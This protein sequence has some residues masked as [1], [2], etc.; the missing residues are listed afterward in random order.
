M[1]YIL[2]LFLLLASSFPAVS[3]DAPLTYDRI[4]LSGTATGEVAN[5]TVVALLYAQ[6][7]GQQAATLA[8][9]VNAAI[10]WALAQAAGSEGIKAQTLDYQTQPVYQNQRLSGWRVR[11]SLRLEGRDAGSLA[12]LVGT[13]QAR[14]AVQSI[15][16]Q[17]SPARQREA[18]EALIV[19]AIAAFRGRAELVREQL[20]AA[21]YRLVELHVD[22]GGPV[23]M[24]RTAMATM[25][26]R[27]A[28]APPALEPGT[29][30]LSVSVSGTI[31]LERR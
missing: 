3:G 5:D 9:E 15:G 6:R 8:D 26:M 14:L 19:E 17:V 24:P 2:L 11:Q 29:R 20:G 7:E 13:L 31:E 10:A 28:A 1:R 18:E 23:P 27:G 25:E 30:D 21:G 12:G 16:Y 22:G 4:H